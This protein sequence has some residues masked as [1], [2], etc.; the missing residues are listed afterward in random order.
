MNPHPAKVPL[1]L[2]HEHGFPQVNAFRQ[3]NSLTVSFDG[4]SYG[5]TP[6]KFARVSA[7]SKPMFPARILRW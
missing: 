6:V 3:A 1:I 4:N 7:E 2:P 5:F